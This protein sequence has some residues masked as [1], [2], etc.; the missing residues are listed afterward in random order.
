MLRFASPRDP[1]MIAD[2]V[3]FNVIDTEKQDWARGWTKLK[4]YMEREGHARVPY[5]HREDAYPLGKWVAEQRRVYGAGQMIG[6]RARRLEKLGM[7]W[8]PADERFQENLAAARAYYEEHWTLCVPRTATALDRP[9]GQ[10]LSN[11]RRPEALEGHPE[12]ETALRE[13]DEDWN[14][15]WPADWQRHY[16]AVRELP[17]EE[18]QTEVLPGVMVHGMDV[19]KWLARQ[20]QQTIWQRLLDGQ[21]ERLE[22][23]GIVPLPPQQEAP[24][25]PS[26]SRT[27]AFERGVA[28]LAHYKARTGSVTV[29][30]GHVETVVIDG[31]EHAVK[32]GI[33]LSNTKTRRGKL[34]EDKLQ[35]L[36][37]LGLEWATA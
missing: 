24:P 14:P 26:K 11:L 17:R 30:R 3:S 2:W 27:G 33:F 28:A 12:W 37:D 25:K 15:A 19:G 29:P 5:G 32:L 18:H 31:Q 8:S 20:R 9:I 23:L 36:A 10:W 34:T 35:Q 7:V 21:R 6:R 16:A 22:Q 1:V 4:A 13:V